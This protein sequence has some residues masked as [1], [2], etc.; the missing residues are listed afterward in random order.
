MAIKDWLTSAGFEEYVPAFIENRIDVELLP[1][2]SNDD[3][4]DLGVER[5]G[6]RKR[7]LKL[8]SN[9]VNVTSPTAVSAKGSEM[10]DSEKRQVTV[11]FADL[12]GFTNLSSKLG[13]EGTHE[14]LNKY[15]ST[16]DSIIENHGGRIDKHIGD[17]VMAVFGA[18][19]AH[20]D[21]P[22]RA[23]HSAIAI[24]K[25][26]LALNTGQPHYAHVGI[27]SGQVMAS[28]T[29]SDAHREYTVTGDSVN[30]ASRLQD[31]AKPG[32]TLISGALYQMVSS[33]ANCSILDNIALKGIEKPVSVWRV[34][35]LRE[36]S[37]STATNTLVGRDVELSQFS[38]TLDV[39]LASGHGQAVV[40][41]GEAG[42]GKT[43]LITEFSEIARRRGC[44]CHRGL[45]LDFGVGKGQEAIPSIVRSLLKIESDIGTPS[46]TNYIQ[47]VFDNGRL[48]E[49]QRIFLNDLL[50]LSQSIDEQIRY[51]A[52]NNNE[53]TE[54]KRAV[55]SS[56]IFNQEKSE[57][58]LLIIEDVHW[59]S[60]SILDD[61]AH[62]ARTIANANGILL[63]TSRIDS[64]PLTDNWRT[65]IGSCSLLTI[66]LGPLRKSDAIKLANLHQETLS[67]LSEETIIRAGGNPLFLEQLLHNQIEH[68]NDDVP[69]SIQSLVLARIDRLPAKEKEALQAAS[70]L[71]QRF[72]IDTLRYLIQIENYDCGELINR[73]LIKPDGDQFLFAHAL[74]QE[75]VYNSLI[76]PKRKILH[77]RA[78]DYFAQQDL[79][80]AAQ[81]LDRGEDPNA[82]AAYLAAAT[83]HAL[84]YRF[85]S[86]ASLT[87]RGIE[88]CNDDATLCSLLCVRGESLTHMGDTKAAIDSFTMALSKSPPLELR[89]D[90]SI[91]LANAFRIS[92]HRD[93]ALEALSEAQKI[94]ETLDIAE[95][96][97]QSHYLRGNILFPTGDY[98]RCLAEHERALQLY[99]KA[100][101][102]Q[103]EARALGGVGDAY[104]LQGR[105]LSSH[106]QFK[107]C[108][109]L[110]QD[111][112]FRQIEAAN[113]PMLGW[114]A[115]Y[116]LE[117][118][119]ALKYG[120]L[121]VD[122]ARELNQRRAELQGLMMS[123]FAHLRLGNL[124]SA[125]SYLQLA[126]E[127][128]K[129]I[130]A[131][132]FRAYTGTILAR[133]VYQRGNAADSRQ[134][135]HNALKWLED[136][137]LPFCGASA[138]AIAACCATDAAESARLLDKGESILNSGAVSHSQFDFAEFAIDA[139]LNLKDFARVNHIVDRLENYTHHEPLPLSN[140]LIEYGRVQASW[141]RNEI[142]E[143]L[144]IETERLYVIATNCNFESI[145]TKLST[146]INTS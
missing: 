145:A 80:L 25:G 24:H 94:A 143:K 90:A 96:L 59:A 134:A 87:K 64:Y 7:I 34:E 58:L 72:A 42:I 17:S 121:A 112:G 139:A 85:E 15:F 127:L 66:D 144:I 111:K 32:E 29:G 109:E 142:S 141:G 119:A 37:P 106:Q 83:S 44:T 39:C 56:L 91:G 132:N 75:G 86:S 50:D 118:R 2:L 54:G 21:D 8:I 128:S 60:K 22:I 31:L 61:I 53:R 36:W 26:M 89:Y 100:R 11:L 146:L 18:P 123:G 140:L 95:K 28:K 110:C 129:K 9:L 76:A 57:P 124:Q 138:Y 104:Y 114:T 6:D 99:Q 93:S 38:S 70:V 116:T 27:A 98:T 131:S 20:G 82:S 13:S 41:R 30:L 43:R 12:F 5:L 137:Y 63:L 117:L 4:K 97:A 92:D 88:L 103:G 62:L 73:Q 84:L 45:V 125:E 130:G 107:A 33:Q 68:G 133:L 78:A 40:V 105:M 51:D 135:S 65:K 23:I 81:H 48:N 77:R 14:L 52:L 1:E 47:A 10:P 136:S 79:L 74:V 113:R 67:N 120:E 115:G 16:V 101:S 69:P 71:G 122:L 19:I 126:L 3:L 102:S 55:I 49:S 108:I 46:Y 35:S